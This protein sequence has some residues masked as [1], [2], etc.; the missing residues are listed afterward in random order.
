VYE[1]LSDQEIERAGMLVREQVER[2]AGEAH[3]A[4]ARAH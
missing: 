2:L 1:S 4:R 3:G